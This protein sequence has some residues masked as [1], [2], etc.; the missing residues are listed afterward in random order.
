[1]ED[2]VCLDREGNVWSFGRN[3]GGELGLGDIHARYTPTKIKILK[4][5][6]QISCKTLHT[7]CLDDQGKVWVFGN[8]KCGQL[9]LGGDNDRLEPVM[10][11]KLRDVISVSVGN[12]QSLCIIKP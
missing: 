7:L 12:S 8:S 1:V 2:S 9:G 11:A 3:D 6:I 10:N 5:I 4:N